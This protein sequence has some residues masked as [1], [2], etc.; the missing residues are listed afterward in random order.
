MQE[1]IEYAEMLEIPVS[2]INVVKRRAKHK[3]QAALQQSL[4]QQV[5]DRMTFSE[6]AESGEETSQDFSTHLIQDEPQI[7]RVRKSR[8]KGE[9]QSSSKAG[10]ILYRIEFACACALCLGIFLTNVFLPGSAINTF[11][12][13]M[14]TTPAE[15]DTRV[16]SDFSL[17]SVVGDFSDAAI[18]VSSEG[19]ISF[20]AEGCVYPT[21]D[22]TVS[23]VIESEGKYTVKISHTPT[24][25]SVIEGVD[26]VYYQVGEEVKHNVPIAYSVGEGLVQVTMYEEGELLNC[27]AL[28]EQNCLTWLETAQ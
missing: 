8:Q 20:T 16:F 18:D 24:F 4:I 5:N 7:K 27:F 26:Q 15:E 19:V 12:R 3:K 2:T 22:G 9:E 17:S 23:D 6:E 10:R 14:A 13:Y 11:F 28:D 1:E 21:V 25:T